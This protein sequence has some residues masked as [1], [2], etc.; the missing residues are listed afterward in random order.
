MENNYGNAFIPKVYKNGMT[1]MANFIHFQKIPGFTIEEDETGKNNQTQVVL[2]LPINMRT[3]NDGTD[4]N[5]QTTVMASRLNNQDNRTDRLAALGEIIVKLAH[6][7]RN[8]LGSIQLYASTLI[9]DLEGYNEL[10]SL[11][12][13]INKGVETINNIISNALLFVNPRQKP[14][15]DII[16]INETIVDTLLFSNHLTETKDEINVTTSLSSGPLNING[17]P[18]LLKQV[19]L[20][21]ILNSVQAMPDGGALKIS[22][23]SETVKGSGYGI[24][25]FLDTGKGICE[26]DIPKI[27]DPFFTTK[28]SGTGLGMSIV[29]NIIKIHGGT[30]DIESLKDKGVRCTVKLPL[31]KA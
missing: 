28:P 22:T 14:E 3:E 29:H 27:F 21:L 8:P 2:N 25:E 9:Y 23:K 6:E 19:Y 17:D 7:I 24:I 13:H 1:D 15:F 26:K 10:K 30:V 18:A 5:H 31:T 4:P 20:N 12:E 16:N 11:A